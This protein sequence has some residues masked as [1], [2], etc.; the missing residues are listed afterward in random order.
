M[1]SK[2]DPILDAREVCLQ[3]GPQTRD[4]LLKKLEALGWHGDV[5]KKAVEAAT[6]SFLRF[7]GVK[8]SAA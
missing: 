7:A 1:Q 8:Y 3:D 6:G 5:C 4:A 2:N